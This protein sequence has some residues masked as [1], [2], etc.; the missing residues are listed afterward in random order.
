[1]IIEVNNLLAEN[2]KA[3]QGLH[4]IASMD[5]QQ[6]FMIIERDGNFTYNSV[7]K[8]L[9]DI[10]TDTHNIFMIYKAFTYSGEKRFELARLN[11]GKFEISR[12]TIQGY[13]ANNGWRWFDTAYGK[14]E[15]ETSRKSANGHYFIIAQ[16]KRFENKHTY[17]YD[18]K[19]RFR[20]YYWSHG[21]SVTAATP[22]Y[23]NSDKHY[24]NIIKRGGYVTEKFVFDKSGYI[25]GVNKY[26]HRL[27]V[28][29]R[30][31]SKAEAAK[32]DNTEKL[33]E[34]TNRIDN[35]K[36]IMI[37]NLNGKSPNYSAISNIS[38]KIDW[39]EGYMKR[40]KDN[41]FK[42]VSEIERTLEYID[43]YISEAENVS[44]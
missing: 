23:R 4:A 13:E 1:M 35:L 38:Q 14:G 39:N 22:Y 44:L 34:Y 7:M 11:D 19:D 24:D 33:T 30:E 2:R 28:V 21:K 27:L 8:K 25:Q 42:S 18:K 9:G 43:K 3:L 32:F 40:L 17:V 41:D 5:F 37:R 12:S 36:A 15:F 20:L 16:E 29:K 31:K 10:S 26:Q 6:P